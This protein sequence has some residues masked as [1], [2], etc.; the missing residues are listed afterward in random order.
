[1]ANE[2]QIPKTKEYFC[3]P[4]YWDVIYAYIQVNSEWDGVI[5]HPRI[6]PKKKANFTKIGEY[7]GLTRQ[8]VS[9]RF[10]DLEDGQKDKEGLNLIKKLENGDYEIAILDS[11]VATLINN[12]TLRV[13][14]SSCNNY[15]ISIYV[16]LYSRWM[17]QQQQEFKFTYDQLK[18]IIGIGSKSDSNDYII[19]DILNLLIM[20]ELIE[21]KCNN[22][23]T[24]NGGFKTVYSIIKMKD[25]VTD[26]IGEMSE[27]ARIERLSKKKC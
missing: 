24:E 9:K 18:Q 2:R 6:L 25:T 22:E 16:Y 19:K 8:T 23:L 26:I 11:N 13:L 21:L 3:N 10:Q 20:M 4:L 17:A 14:T 27:Q 15:T 1:M 12:D 7:L 5:G